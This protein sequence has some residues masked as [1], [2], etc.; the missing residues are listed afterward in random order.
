[1][2]GW[3]LV[4]V[5]AF[6][7]IGLRAAGPLVIGTR[8]LPAPARRALPLL[9]PAVFAALVATGALARGEHLHPDAR[10]AGLAA[11]AV[12]VWRRAPVIVV[13]VVAAG[14]AALVRLAW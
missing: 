14:T 12:A 9:A 4:A 2:N 6:V 1:V 11:A 10:L 8:R 3:L 5:L 7:A 13:L